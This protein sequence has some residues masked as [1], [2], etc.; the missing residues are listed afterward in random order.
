M[1]D[2]SVGRGWIVGLFAVAVMWV[3]LLLGVSFLATPVKFLAPSLSLAVALDVGRHTFAVFNKVEW[4]LAVTALLLLFGVRSRFSAL[5]IILICAVVAAET[6]WLLPELDRRVVL[7]IAGQ[8]PPASTRHSL[9][10]VL[11]IV[12]LVALIAVTV[13]MARKLLPR[14]SP[15]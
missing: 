13:E 11:E 6:F 2:G 1:M 8:Q 5:M 4:L 9:Y 14:S 7:I 12:K 3:G 10:V 15:S